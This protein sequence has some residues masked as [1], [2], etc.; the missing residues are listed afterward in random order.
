MLLQTMGTN[1]GKVASDISNSY[2]YAEG[3][4]SHV[5][6]PSC[7]IEYVEDILHYL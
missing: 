1:D 4:L 2:K 7:H 5:R 3:N 6:L